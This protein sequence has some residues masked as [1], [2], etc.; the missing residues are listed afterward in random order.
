MEYNFTDKEE[1]VYVNDFYKRY[2]LTMQKTIMNLHCNAITKLEARKQREIYKK[3]YDNE[4]KFALTIIGK[5]LVR[6]GLK[7]P[8]RKYEYRQYDLMLLVMDYLDKEIL[9]MTDFANFDV[10]DFY[11]KYVKER[12]DDLQTY[13]EEMQKKYFNKNS[14]VEF[15]YKKHMQM[16]ENLIPTEEEIK[17]KNGYEV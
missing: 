6:F 8:Y 14:K 12:Y 4:T 5:M 1:L 11:V 3:R 13:E 10:K 16:S 9:Y 7:S 2:F 17:E 15:D